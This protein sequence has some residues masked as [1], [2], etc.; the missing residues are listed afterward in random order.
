MAQPLDEP[1]LDPGLQLRRGQRTGIGGVD[2]ADELQSKGDALP[3]QQAGRTR[4]VLI[5]GE[6]DEGE[7]QWG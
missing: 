2:V 7:E 6:S 1:R 4:M 3:A 5:G